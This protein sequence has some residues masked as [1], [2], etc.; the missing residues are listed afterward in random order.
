[1]STP[2]LHHMPSC[3]LL[4]REAYDLHQTPGSPKSR[5]GSDWPSCTEL[6]MHCLKNIPFVRFFHVVHP[7]FHPVLQDVVRWSAARCPFPWQT[8]ARPLN[9]TASQ[10]LSAPPTSRTGPTS[11]RPAPHILP[12]SRCAPSCRRPGP[13][14][15]RKRQAVTSGRSARVDPGAASVAVAQGCMPVS[16]GSVSQRTVPICRL[17]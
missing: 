7:V 1:M 2:P 9:T 13:R 14:S 5:G 6:L 16:W 3:C 4:L 15:E 8:G 11:W 10:T 17:E 12:P